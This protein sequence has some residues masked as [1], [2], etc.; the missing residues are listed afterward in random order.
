MRNKPSILEVNFIQHS[1]S[2]AC[3]ARISEGL[4]R[5]PGTNLVKLPMA[6]L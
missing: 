4:W 5:F 1:E 6:Q 3:Q 2:F